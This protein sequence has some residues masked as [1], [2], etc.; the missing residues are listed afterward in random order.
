MSAEDI[1]PERIGPWGALS[2]LLIQAIKDQPPEV[3]RRLTHGLLLP[4]PAM[5]FALAREE[6]LEIIR[7]ATGEILFEGALTAVSL[8]QPSQGPLRPETTSVEFVLE[9]TARRALAQ[10]HTVQVPA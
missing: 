6:L 3:I 1:C 9:R 4:C 7:R 5:Q 8:I 10:L 2:E